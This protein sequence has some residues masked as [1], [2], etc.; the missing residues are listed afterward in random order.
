MAQAY[1]QSI[2]LPNLLHIPHPSSRVVQKPELNI[3]G[4]NAATTVSSDN[5]NLKF[6]AR[7]NNSN[8]NEMKR[9]RSSYIANIIGFIINV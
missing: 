7:N 1:F 4:T 3:E 5:V 9:C 8:E 6:N 2:K